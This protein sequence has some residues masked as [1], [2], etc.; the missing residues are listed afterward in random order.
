MIFRPEEMDAAS[1]EWPVFCPS[2]EGDIC[3]SA[4][5]ARVF[6]H[7]DAVTHDNL[8]EL[9]A[10]KTR[11]INLD[12]LSRKYPADRQGFKPSLSKPFLL[13]F[14]S[15]TILIRQVDERRK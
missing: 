12:C 8:Q 9:T 15:N 4:D 13:P 2:T 10:I 6:T 11:R 1:C 7:Y 14:D 3:V 5:A